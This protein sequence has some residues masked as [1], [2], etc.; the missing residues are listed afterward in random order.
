MM[1]ADTTAAATL[2]PHN[3]R[4]QVSHGR[5]VLHRAKRPIRAITGTALES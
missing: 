2:S 5:D 1:I 3:V 4:L